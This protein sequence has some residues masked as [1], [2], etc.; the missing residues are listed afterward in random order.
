MPLYPSPWTARQ[1]MSTI[2]ASRALAAGDPEQGAKKALADYLGVNCSDVLMLSS[3]TTALTLGLKA[4]RR[5][6]ADEVILSTF[7]CPQ[8]ADA[9]LM[10]GMRPILCD[11]GPDL[12]LESDLDQHIT[13]NTVAIIVTNIFGI[14][15]DLTRLEEL[16]ASRSIH[17]IDDGAQ[18]LGAEVGLR[19][20]STRGSFGV[21]SFGRHKPLFAIGGGALI[22]GTLDD[23][24]AV[25][26]ASEAMDRSPV[27]LREL[28]TILA[29]NYSRKINSS[30]PIR[31]GLAPRPF[32]D[33]RDALA[34]R[35]QNAV[36]QR[37][38][39]LSASLV[40]VG[41]PRLDEYRDRN[42]AYR[43]MYQR[44]VDRLPGL[45]LVGGAIS[46][47]NFL[48]LSCEISRF[49]LAAVFAQN[50]IETNWLYYPLHRQPQYAQ[51]ART[52]G[53][54]QAEKTWPIT[55]CLPC[56]GW[57]RLEQIQHSCSVLEL[58][59]HEISRRQGTKRAAVERLQG[60]C[61]A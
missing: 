54:P 24:D 5:T 16:C 3:G 6:P 60:E 57:H 39:L 7:N 53:F 37:I 9:V 17:L 40:T 8:V 23:L 28:S 55:L 4:V 25:F 52:G 31:L 14:T 20:V 61:N 51:F 49:D 18:A 15:S 58:A 10:A 1:L 29:F 19:K 50:G 46:E 48:T 43:E 22:K 47:T 13:S 30:L 56:R 42:R 38:S 59:Y 26:A 34:M 35:S 45:S 32:A 12:N 33:V 41:L 2:V 36:L 27:G 44:T 11:V 21:L